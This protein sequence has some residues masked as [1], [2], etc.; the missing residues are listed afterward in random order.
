MQQRL[1]LVK[2][3]TF[4]C[5]AGCTRYGEPAEQPRGR[6]PMSQ[7]TD[8]LQSLYG[9]KYRRRHPHL[10]QPVPYGQIPA[11]RINALGLWG[12]CRQM[13]CGK[14]ASCRTRTD[15]AQPPVMLRQES[16]Q[17]P[18]VALHIVN[19]HAV[20]FFCPEHRQISH[21]CTQDTP[22]LWSREMHQVTG[23]CDFMFRIENA[24]SRHNRLFRMQN[25]VI[26]LRFCNI[27]F[28]NFK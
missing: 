23:Q 27:E 15:L 21:V 19:D 1:H 11:P 26:F 2:G 7:F 13:S 4:V 6:A 20:A 8:A 9:R 12:G 24:E 14:H 3:S 28:A 18:T 5:H 16:V 10:A 25:Y 22:R 17:C